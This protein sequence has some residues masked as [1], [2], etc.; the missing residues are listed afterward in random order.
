MG[1]GSEREE[2]FV[3][4]EMLVVAAAAFAPAPPVSTS[5]TSSF[6]PPP[7]R[8]ASLPSNCAATA[9]AA[10]A[11]ASRASGPSLTPG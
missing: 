7:P 6:P 5:S 10:F 1:R 9:L 2:A 8:A 4:L 11:C 3:D